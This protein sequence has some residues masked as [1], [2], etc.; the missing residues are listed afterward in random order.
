MKKVSIIIELLIL[1]ASVFGQSPFP[2]KQ[3]MGSV[4]T[5]VVS[6]GGLGSDTVFYTPSFSDTTAA[7]RGPYA[8]YYPGNLIRTGDSVWMR[9]KTSTKWL[10]LHGGIATTYYNSNVGTGF[11]WVI[12]NTNNVK[13][14]A[15]VYP[16]QAD[17]ATS[18]VITFSLDTASGKWRSENYYNTVYTPLTRSIATGYGLMGGG[19]FTTNRTHIVDSATLFANLLSTIALTTVG[20]GAATWN[21]TTRILNIPTPSTNYVSAVTGTYPIASSGGLTPDISID[22]SSGKWRSEN[23]YN[24][25]YTPLTR[26]LN[27][28]YGVNSIGNFTADR[29]VSIDSNTLFSNLLATVALTQNAGSTSWNPT[30]RILNIAPQVGIDT[31]DISDFYIKVRSLFTAG[32]GITIVNGQISST[33]AGRF[34]VSGEDAS[35]SQTRAFD[36]NGNPFSIG[37]TGVNVSLENSAGIQLLSL[38]DTDSSWSS[39]VDIKKD[40]IRLLPHLGILNIDSLRS[41]TSIADSSYKRIMTW[42]ER[43]GRWEYFDGYFPAK[44]TSPVLTSE[45]NAGD[46]QTNLS[47]GGYTKLRA[48]TGVAFNIDMSGGASAGLLTISNSGLVN[49]TATDD[50][51]FDISITGTTTKD[52]EITTTLTTG[53]V[54]FAGSGGAINEDNSKFFYDNSNDFLGLGTNTPDVRFDVIGSFSDT[55]LAEFNNTNGDGQGI[56]VKANSNASSLNIADFQGSGG[57]MVAFKSNGAVAFAG[58]VGTSGQILKSNGSGGS[59][60]WIDFPYQTFSTSSGSNTVTITLSNGGSIT[61]QGDEGTTITTSGTSLNPIIT[62]SSHAH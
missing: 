1:A 44:A 55:Y 7:N 2:T 45:N 6:R 19:N 56:Y 10:L 28:G 51:G 18:N 61:L 17:S 15:V 33:D 39:R 9:N 53:S 34:G 36:I 47:T 23:Y 14:A 52:I 12:P 41:W 38:S 30:T 20:S 11:R 13:T 54:F 60:T 35:A 42:D 32:P 27:N 26:T 24:T 22:T 3:T 21:S 8:R 31:T 29:T 50:N 25:V 16:V 5:L 62:I 48:G 4:Q 43:N 59:P 46:F 58:S 57:S 49:V 40:S 37:G